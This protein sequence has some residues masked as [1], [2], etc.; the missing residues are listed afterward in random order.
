LDAND[1]RIT[2]VI[3]A[4]GR[5]IQCGHLVNAA[6]AWSGALAKLSDIMLPVEPRKRYVYVIDS[7]RATEAMRAGPLTVDPSG[8]WMRPEGRTFLCGISPDE[9]NEPPAVDLDHID[10]REFEEIV[11]PGLAA[12]IPAFEEAKL[13]NAWAGFYDYNTLDQNAI[14]GAH[15]PY[16]NMYFATGF[17]GHGL[18]QAYA[19]GRGVAELI[20]HGSFRTID[21]ARFGYG[22]VARGEPL[23]ELNVI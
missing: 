15:V 19:A 17:S 22:R 20:V 21:L 11:W 4:D 8:V 16:S 7:K 14:I 5:R 9:A 6:G 1:N 18:Q 2:G 13:L 3:L 10:Y 12:R 23:F